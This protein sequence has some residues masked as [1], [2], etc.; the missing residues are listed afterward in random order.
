MELSIIRT[1][2]IDKTDLRKIKIESEEVWVKAKQPFT[3][4]VRGKTNA[5]MARCRRQY[6]PHT[7]AGKAKLGV[8]DGH[9]AIFWRI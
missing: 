3:H 5:R 7:P 1:L 6:G 4:A 9:L 8:A 2:Q